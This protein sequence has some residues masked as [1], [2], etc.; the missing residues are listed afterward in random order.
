[1]SPPPEN[2]N[3]RFFRRRDCRRQPLRSVAPSPGYVLW[4]NYS[5]PG[6]A[7]SRTWREWPLHVPDRGQ[8]P[9]PCDD[10][11]YFHPFSGLRPSG[12]TTPPA[13]RGQHQLQGPLFTGFKIFSVSHLESRCRGISV[14]LRH[15]NRKGPTAAIKKAMAQL[16]EVF[17]AVTHRAP[18]S[19]QV[20][21]GLF[22]KGLISSKPNWIQL[23]TTPVR[24]GVN[25]GEARIGLSQLFWRIA[26][27]APFL[28]SGKSNWGTIGYCQSAG[29]C[30]LTTRPI[31][32]T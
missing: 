6:A 13:V 23:I 14:P 3:S 10:R 28:F 21:G 20:V 5:G 16:P 30:S 26:R 7:A 8:K 2:S 22:P 25:H 11:R 32:S 17:Q 19:R 31:R 4:R 24:D 15:L 12:L 18:T 9:R 1:M 27:D 29:P